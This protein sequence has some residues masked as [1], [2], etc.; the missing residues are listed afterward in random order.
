MKQRVIAVGMVGLFVAVVAWGTW[1]G[2]SAG[3]GDGEVIRMVHTYLSPD[4]VAGFAEAI[5]EYEALHP[6]VR[7]EQQTIPFRMYSPWLRTRF[8]GGIA[9]SIIEIPG[10]AMA[11]ELSTYVR[12]L[13]PEIMTPNPYNDGGPLEG[14][15][16][17]DTFINGLRD[18]PNYVEVL[19]GYY[20]VPLS[21]VTYRMLY[22]KELLKKLTGKDAPP[23]NAREFAEL[24][25]EIHRNS[26]KTVVPIAADGR[27]G[28]SLLSEFMRTGSAGTL[29]A[30]DPYGH[31]WNWDDEVAVAKLLGRW[32]FETPALR[33]GL[34]DVAAV[35][36][37]LT[38]GFSEMGAGDS[39]FSF[40][41]ERAVFLV[42]QSFEYSLFM[43]QSDF[44]IGIAPLPIGTYAGE[45]EPG[46]GNVQPICSLG[47]ARDAPHP[48][49]AVDFLRFLTSRQ[50]NKQMV[51]R[52]LWLPVV[53][54]LDPIEE[55]TPF[56]PNLSGDPPGFG[57]WLFGSRE[58]LPISRNL[59]ELIGIRG[60]VDRFVEK[61]EPEIDDELR[62]VLRRIKDRFNRIV[63]RADIVFGALNLAETE[64]EEPQVRND[65]ALLEMQV[66]FQTRGAYYDLVLQAEAEGKAYL[67]ELAGP[68]AEFPPKAATGDATP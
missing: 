44:P 14:T 11:E 1:R 41:Q 54:G 25:A 22:N 36:P 55:L 16:W 59:H 7:I 23:R 67:A 3:G 27:N 19:L 49:R 26:G 42:M 13:T 34:E 50:Q 17:R 48:E 38:P 30:L 45:R 63:S 66:M 28:T 60:D 39:T 24:C 68:P 5:K 46:E 12:E 32:D 58:Q 37:W 40:L 51:E 65:A 4:V 43:D 35:G 62:G 47:V 10:A 20:S 6:G 21:V 31:F 18:P 52:S 8:V 33:A 61:A 64:A 56:A 2:R 15:I 53:R 57:L 9:P 29:M